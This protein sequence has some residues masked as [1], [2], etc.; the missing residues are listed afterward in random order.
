MKVNN[1]YLFFAQYAFFLLVIEVK[2]LERNQLRAEWRKKETQRNFAYEK[3]KRNSPR[4][5]NLCEN[6]K[7]TIERQISFVKI[8]KKSSLMNEIEKER[9]PRR[10]ILSGALLE[11]SQYSCILLI[12]WRYYKSQYCYDNIRDDTLVYSY[13]SEDGKDQKMEER[14]NETSF[15][16]QEKWFSLLFVPMDSVTSIMGWGLTFKIWYCRERRL[17]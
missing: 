1:M 13:L 3:W 16:I 8:E 14:E 12:T 9:D 6:H 17:S 15:K 11:H 10:A 2:Y 7:V 4:Q 5:N